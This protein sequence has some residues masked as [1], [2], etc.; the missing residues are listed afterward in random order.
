MRK[1]IAYFLAFI[2]LASTLCACQG[3][4]TTNP[5]ATTAAS[6]VTNTTDNAQDS[7]KK[8]STPNPG[9]SMEIPERE[10]FATSPESFISATETV[11]DKANY[12]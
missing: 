1:N 8:P 12:S 9:V 5:I 11:I 3:S 7:N 2:M 6:D 4:N 10:D